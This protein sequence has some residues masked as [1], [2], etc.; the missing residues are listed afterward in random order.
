MGYFYSRNIWFL[1]DEAKG[2]IKTA[3]LPFL[4][5]FI[6]LVPFWLINGF[7]FWTATHMFIYGV[8]YLFY[9]KK[10]KIGALALIL[11][12]LTHIAFL[13]P[14]GI[15]IGYFF[16]PKNGWLFIFI[17]L[18]SILFLR[19]DLIF[20]INMIPTSLIE[21]QLPVLTNY[22]NEGYAE[23]RAVQVESLNWYAKYKD[24]PLYIYA[25]STIVILVVYK[26][27]MT[28]NKGWLDIFY[29][30]VLLFSVTTILDVIPSAG[31]LFSVAYLF[32]FAAFFLLVQREEL[33][34]S[35][36][37]YFI[38]GYFVIALPIAIQIR[39]SMDFIGPNTLLYN[40]LFAWLLGNEYALVHFYKGN[41]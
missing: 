21:G 28:Q 24:L 39:I 1:I 12:A 25:I 32:I 5:L 7:R 41:G 14:C 6:F 31:R 22:L 4:L 9:L 10:S 33:N 29:F 16:I 35:L 3:A 34:A 15:V 11:S 26:I 13:L 27:R 36:Q 17:L 40:P 20:F 37:W 38:L 30:G 23:G 2:P 8:I 19:V 18:I